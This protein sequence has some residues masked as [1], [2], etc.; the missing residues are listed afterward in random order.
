[1]GADFNVPKTQ[2]WQNIDRPDDRE[3]IVKHELLDGHFFPN[4]K[5]PQS[6]FTI[7]EN[8]SITIKPSTK[9]SVRAFIYVL[10]VAHI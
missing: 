5:H 7:F 9:I 1:V 4:Q 3:E 10:L 8:N 2:V 6:T